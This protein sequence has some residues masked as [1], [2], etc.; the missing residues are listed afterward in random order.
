[1]IL[2]LDDDVFGP[3]V[4]HSSN[5]ILQFPFGFD[6]V[7]RRSFDAHNVR[8]G[9]LGRQPN[10]HIVLLVQSGH[11]V[12]GFLGADQLRIELGIHGQLFRE[13]YFLQA[14]GDVLE[15]FFDFFHLIGR[16]LHR[17]LVVSLK[18][19]M[20]AGVVGSNFGYVGAL[21]ANHVSV[22]PRRNIYF[23]SPHRI[24]FGN[25]LGESSTKLG[26]FSIQ[27]NGL[28]VRLKLG[29][30]HINIVVLEYV[31]DNRAIFADD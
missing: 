28:A 8:A 16:T 3:F 9:V 25:Y 23:N 13:Q 7:F 19:N 31:L 4:F 12:L 22:Q 30:L 15:S 6:H 5:Q 11:Q 29:H 27:I 14:N 26:L 18:L 21:L 2:L 24:R 17:D 20:G 1:M 10:H